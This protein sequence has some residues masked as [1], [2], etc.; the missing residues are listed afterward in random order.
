[1]SDL[2]DHEIQ[3]LL[4]NLQQDLAAFPA[5]MNSLE[6][7]LESAAKH[8]PAYIK[9]V[10]THID[11][12]RKVL[13]LENHNHRTLEN[14]GLATPVQQLIKLFNALEDEDIQLLEDLAHAAR[15]WQPELT[16]SLSEESESTLFESAETTS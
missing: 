11:Q 4:V 12:L 8:I 9:I 16:G 1:M 3:S 15:N 14:A 10:K 5:G 6:Y 2:S 7:E 13:E